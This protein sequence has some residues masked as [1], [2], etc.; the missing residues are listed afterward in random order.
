V[1]VGSFGVHHRGLVVTTEAEGR[2]VLNQSQCAYEAVTL[3]AICAG[4]VH[5]RAM[6][7]ADILAGIRVTVPALAAA[8]ESRAPLDLRLCFA[9]KK[10]RQDGQGD[11]R[12]GALDQSHN[13]H[14]Q[15]PWP[16]FWPCIDPDGPSPWFVVIASCC[17]RSG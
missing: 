12:E 16:G 4:T 2:L 13:S 6:E 9:G 10:P 17:M 1:L 3:V 7:L 11:C 15:S 14:L 8:L 5:E